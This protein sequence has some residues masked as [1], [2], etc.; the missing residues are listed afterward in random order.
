MFGV[1]TTRKIRQVIVVLYQPPEKE[2][3]QFYFSYITNFEI[4][5][6]Q[7]VNTSVNTLIKRKAAV[8]QR[9]Y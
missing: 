7:I 3:L 8:L 5:G 4:S 1:Y 2:N 9:R 6:C